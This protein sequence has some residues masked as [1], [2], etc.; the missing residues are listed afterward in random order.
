MFDISKASLSSD[1]GPLQNKVG[2]R[3]I[4][5]KGD[6]PKDDQDR[7]SHESTKKQEEGLENK[8]SDTLCILQFGDTCFGF[9]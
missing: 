9:Q 4:I 5:E 3:E 1:L 6:D 7:I 2:Q 8:G